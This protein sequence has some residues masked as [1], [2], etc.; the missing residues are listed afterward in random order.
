MA[1]FHRTRW[2]SRPDYADRPCRLPPARLSY[3]HLLPGELRA[4]DAL[5]ALLS[6][7]LLLLEPGGERGRVLLAP[8][9]QRGL[10]RLRR[11]GLGA[12]HD[13]A[14]EHVLVLAQ[15]PRGADDR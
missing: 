7:P 10:L 3:Q 5:C 9:P 15:A 2:S 12:A 8:G 1:R 4:R 6:G 14:G 11:G 13:R